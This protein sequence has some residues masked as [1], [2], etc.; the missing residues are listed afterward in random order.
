MTGGAAKNFPPAFLSDSGSCR[1]LLKSEVGNSIASKYT[2]SFASTTFAALGSAVGVSS[3]AVPH[4]RRQ[5]MQD[6]VIISVS[7]AQGSGF[8]ARA[9]ELPADGIH[10]LAVNTLRSRVSRA[11]PGC[12]FTLALNK[13]A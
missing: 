13:R 7:F 10:A 8:V 2:R 9:K 5:S 4:I 1:I 3:F 11:L 6:R 12:E